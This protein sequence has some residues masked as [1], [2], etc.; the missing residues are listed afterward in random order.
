MYNRLT[1]GMNIGSKWTRIIMVLIIANVGVFLLQLL[2]ST[3]SLQWSPQLLNTLTDEQLRQ[4]SSYPWHYP[5]SDKFTK[6]FWLYPPDTLGRLWLWQFFTYMFLHSTTDPWHVIFNML[7][8]WM[9]GSE[10][11]R[12]IGPRRFLTLYFTAGIFAGICCCVFTPGT[13]ILGASGAIFAIEV[14]FAMYFPNST[15]IFYFFPIKA[16]YLVLIFASLTIFSCIIPKSDNVAHFAHLG[17]LVYGFLFVRYSYRVEEYLRKWQMHQQERELTKDHELRVKVDEILDKVN[18][19]G[20]RNLT[21]RERSFLKSAS[22]RYKK[23][24]ELKN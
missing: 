5:A 22:K 14:A 15:V 21:W 19:E 18:R 23:N 17:G 10:V 7:V 8:L 3:V 13:P 20:L 16:K 24:K 1:F 9:F 2:F 6:L 4:A 12:A 11:E